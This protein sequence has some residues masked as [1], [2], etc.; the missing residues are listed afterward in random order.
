MQSWQ[1]IGN[2]ARIGISTEMLTRLNQEGFA[3]ATAVMMVTTP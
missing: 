2:E 1:A 3:I